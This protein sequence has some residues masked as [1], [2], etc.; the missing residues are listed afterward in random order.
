MPV[1]ILSVST[2]LFHPHNHPERI[3]C[4]VHHHDYRIPKIGTETESL[5]ESYKPSKKQ[6]RVKTS[7]MGLPSPHAEPL[8]LAMGFPWLAWVELSG[9]WGRFRPQTSDFPHCLGKLLIN[10]LW[11]HPGLDGTD[12][13]TTF[14]FSLSGLIL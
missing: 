1:T 8:P 5:T 11:L 9:F 6:D 10:S 14:N 3:A 7:T 13:Q 12:P 2:Q 4:K